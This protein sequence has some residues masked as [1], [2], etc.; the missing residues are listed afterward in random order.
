MPTKIIVRG[1]L[2]L[3]VTVLGFNLAGCSRLLPPRKAEASSYELVIDT[4]RLPVETLSGCFI[5][6]VF[7][8]VTKLPIYFLQKIP[9]NAK[10]TAV[11]SEVILKEGDM[12]VLEPVIEDNRVYLKMAVPAVDS[13][14]SYHV[15]VYAKYESR[16]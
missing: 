9:D 7:P 11:R 6:A 4:R 3:L 2:L 13:F 5:P 16:R 8:A 14:S 10:F 1:V 12:K 15:I